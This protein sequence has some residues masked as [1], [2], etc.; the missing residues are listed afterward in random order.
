MS[1]EIYNQLTKSD[2]TK[3]YDIAGTG[4]IDVDGKV[5]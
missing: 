1:L 3:G 4:T 5:Y 2:E